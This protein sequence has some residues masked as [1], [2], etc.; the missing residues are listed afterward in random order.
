[1]TD[2]TD[3]ALDPL[4]ARIASVQLGAE[5]EE[6]GKVIAIADGLAMVDGLPGAELN[7]IVTFATGARG[8][9]LTLE[10]DHLNVACLDP[11][12]DV[13]AGM[14]VTRT[15]LLASVPVGEDLFGRVL[16]PL[17]R[18]L[19]NEPAP[20]SAERLPV[21]RPAP[22]I[23]DRDFV[24]EPV[25]TGLLV[26]DALFAIG[27][28]QRE[29]IIGERQTGKTSIAVDTIINQAGSDMISIYVAIGQRSSAVRHVIDAVCLPPL[30]DHHT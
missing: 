29:L 24:S 25:E 14:R 17:G 3:P 28:G 9:V 4:K 30:F 8:F 11:A 15:G 27:R 16:D 1:M 20:D 7:E 2:Q 18:P 21:E 23:I 13:A 5:A 10:E 6:R 19:D 26:V 12:D 22:S